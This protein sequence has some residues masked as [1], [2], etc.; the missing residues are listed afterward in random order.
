M[1]R[2]SAFL[3]YFSFFDLPSWASRMCNSQTNEAVYN[4]RFHL[5]LA[6]ML[7]AFMAI[8]AIVLFLSALQQKSIRL[9]FS[10]TLTGKL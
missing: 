9:M 7:S 10:N 5:N 4:S 8:A 3:F 1:I 2:R 6:T